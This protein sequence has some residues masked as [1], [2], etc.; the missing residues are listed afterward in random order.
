MKKIIL[1]LIIPMFMTSVIAQKP[2][3]IKTKDIPKSITTFI[4][5][6]LNSAPILRAAFSNENGNLRYYVFIENRGR[7]SVYLF[8]KNGKLLDRKPSMAD[9]E[10]EK[11][12]ISPVKKPVAK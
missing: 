9:F 2:T 11:K 1:L 8:D 3:E 10:K 4:K 7:K 5:K 6:N 12:N